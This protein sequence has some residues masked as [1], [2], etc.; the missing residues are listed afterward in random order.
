MLCGALGA[1]IGWLETWRD[2]RGAYNGF[3]VHRTEGKRM[4]RVHDTAWTQSAMVRGYGNL[5]RASGEQRWSDAM[6]RAADL[7]ASRYDPKTGRLHYTGHEDDRFQSLVSCALGVCALLT[8][9]DLVDDTR[10]KRYTAL[11]ADHA[12]RYW[13]DVLWVET[14]GAFKFSETD[15]YSP[16]EDRF[17]VNFNAMAAEAL[18]AIH[19]ATGQSE[20]RDR[21]LAVGA[22]LLARWDETQ[23]ANEA[24]LAGQV[25]VADDPDSDWMAPGGFSYQFTSTNRT[26]D[27]YVTLYQGLSLRGFQALYEATG[28]PRYAELIRAQGAYILAMRDPETR[29]FYH[30][31]RGGKVEKNPQFIAG[32]G[33]TLLGLHEVA[34]LLGDA[35]AASDTVA[36]VLNSAYRNGSYPGFIGKNDTGHAKRNSGGV[37]WEDVVASANWNAQWF[38][39]LTRLVDDPANVDVA[40]CA[41]TV[42]IV[43]PRFVYVD[44]PSTITIASWSPTR[45]LGLYRYVKSKPGTW[46]SVYP[47]GI[48]A[49]LRTWARAQVRPT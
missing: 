18:L 8:V 24:L 6:V 49:R 26:P 44:T 4:G 1:L 16:G 20:F 7:L 19:A 25:T 47:V 38:E 31:A 40:P 13:F 5:Y 43:N 27:N 29:L 45:S 33:M 34:P 36:S 37:V 14:E 48:Y 39:Y 21:A 32:A 12:R 11:S 17:V 30:T 35:A 42:R 9:A 3:V 41:E 23:A 15:F 10:R 28:D 46:L 22:W 2:D